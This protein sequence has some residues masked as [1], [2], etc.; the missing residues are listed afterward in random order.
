FPLSI[1]IAA[2]STTSDVV[3]DNLFIPAI[4]RMGV[5]F[6]LALVCWYK[7]GCCCNRENGEGLSVTGSDDHQ[8]RPLSSQIRG[9][10]Q[11]GSP[12][13]LGRKVQR[14]PAPPF[15]PSAPGTPPTTP[16]MTQTSGTPQYGFQPVNPRV[17]MAVTPSDIAASNI[18]QGYWPRDGLRV[19]PLSPG[20]SWTQVGSG[21]EHQR[22]SQ[23]HTPNPYAA[24]G[25]AVTP[26]PQP[27]SSPAEFGAHYPA[28]ASDPYGGINRQYERDQRWSDGRDNAAGDTG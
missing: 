18:N 23:Y 22:P 26:P 14:K 9:Q 12:N 15:V 24:T 6:L 3:H 11:P 19:S 16:G 8:P 1:P 20:Q 27:Q 13:T 5:V 25:Y 10:E 7:L 2:M 21:S 4:A 28:G 17:P